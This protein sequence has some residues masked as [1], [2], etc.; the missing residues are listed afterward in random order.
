MNE[1][2]YAD[3]QAGQSE[4]FSVTVTEAMM[5]AF[6]AVSGDTNPLHVSDEFAQSKG[7]DKRV[8]YGMLTASF[9]SQLAGVH[10]PGKNC[11]LQELEI[12]FSKP[13]FAGDCLTVTGKVT[14]KNDLF[15]RIVIKAEVRNQAGDKVSK[16][17]IKAGVMDE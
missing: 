6:C 8:V 7:F 13:V 15:K 11:L 4:H 2:K 16:A 3:I 10:L 12:S 1:Y 17:K 14:E 5:D 9:Y